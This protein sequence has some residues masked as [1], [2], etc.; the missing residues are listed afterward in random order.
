[1]EGDMVAG[2][3][4]MA[5]SLALA[6]AMLLAA[7]AVACADNSDALWNIV[8]GQ[9]VPDQRQN[10]NPAPCARVDIDGGFA[11]LK[12]R[13]G[14]TQYLL[15]PTARITGIESPALLDPGARN[16]F[17]DAW[18]MRGLVEAR[19]GRDLPR[20][21]IGLAVN[22]MFGRSQNQMHIHIDCLAADIRDAL[23][24]NEP[25]IGHDWSPL[26]ETLRGQH[27]LAMKA[28]GDSLPVDPFAGLADGVPDARS[29]MGSY[30]LVAA[31]ITFSDGQ[32]GFVLLADRAMPETADRGSGE[33]LQDHDCAVA[34]P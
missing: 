27:Y 33:A 11:V 25:L 9:C 19:A 13:R 32:P 18:S 17:A 21:D 2:A 26:A 22:S 6:L 34:K 15:I 4:M 23:H 29:S 14:A 20:D 1:M 30:T 7:G 12:D 8:D 10:G 16:Y 24:R 31:G 28:A 3:A 5:R